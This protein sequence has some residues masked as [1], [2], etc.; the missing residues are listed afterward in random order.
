MQDWRYFCLFL[1]FRTSSPSWHAHEGQA[2][3]LF[4]FAWTLQH[5]A[6]HAAPGLQ[7]DEP[8]RYRRAVLLAAVAFLLALCGGGAIIHVIDTHRLSEQRQ[9]AHAIGSSYAHALYRQAD[10]SL[11]STLALAIDMLQSYGGITVLVL[12]PHGVITHVYPLEGREH[13]IGVDLLNNPHYRTEAWAAIPSTTLSLAGPFT[14]A[15]SGQDVVVGRLPVFIVDE[16]G[17]RFWGSPAAVVLRH[18]GLAW[19]RLYYVIARIP[20]SF[21]VFGVQP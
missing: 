1:E 8:M 20:A 6:S 21:P 11:S 10:R 9:A 7:G 16:D 2:H 19:G 3:R 12:A 5:H 18:K 15:G 17:E 13:V 4:P 14:M